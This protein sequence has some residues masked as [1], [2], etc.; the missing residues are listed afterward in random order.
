MASSVCFGAPA[1][2]AKIIDG[3]TFETSTGDKIRLIGINAPEISDIFGQESKR[4]LEILIESKTVELIKD[5]YSSD[6]DRYQRLLRY[7]YIENTDINQKMVNDGYAFAY[8]KYHFEKENEYRKIQLFAQNNNVGIWGSSDKEDI[9]TQQENKEINRFSKSY[10]KKVVVGLLIF[11]LV[12]MG[13]I[14]FFK[15]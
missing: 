14:Y 1:I 4:Y 3:D 11:V 12:L 6:R 15:K 13:S 9:I 8:L 10:S 2:V 5:T 7:V